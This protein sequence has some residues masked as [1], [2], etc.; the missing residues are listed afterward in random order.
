MLPLNPITLQIFSHNPVSKTTMS[1][2]LRPKRKN[3]R[4]KEVRETEGGRGEGKCRQWEGGGA[5]GEQ[6]K[7]SGKP[8]E[9]DQSEEKS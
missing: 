1:Y 5:G 8:R 7:G 3:G 6:G 4:L 9:K 2:Y